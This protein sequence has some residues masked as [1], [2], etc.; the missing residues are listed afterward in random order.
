METAKNPAERRALRLLALLGG[1]LALVIALAVVLGPRGG[2]APTG[3]LAGAAIGGA[4]ALVNQDG[5]PVRDT[6]LTGRYRLM[7]F[8]YTFCPDVCPVSLA[9]NA[10]AL[11]AFYKV[12]EERAARV[13]P[14]FVTVDP[15]RDTPAVLRAFVANFPPR[16]VGLTGSPAAVRAATAKWKVYAAKEPTP[17]RAGYLMAHSDVTYLMGPLGQPIAFFP[18]QDTPETVA[19][20]LDRYVR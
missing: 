4:F 18:G 7:Y 1:G 6:D 17:G 19:R 16:L 13:Q 8:G 12:N 15:E 10:A 20:A 5:K 14:L 3:P 11:R 2:R 9:R